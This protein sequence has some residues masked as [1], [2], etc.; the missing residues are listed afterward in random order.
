MVGKPGADIDLFNFVRRL[1]AAGVVSDV[2]AGSR[3][4]AEKCIED[5]GTLLTA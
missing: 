3:M 1:Y 4:Y 5:G 2:A